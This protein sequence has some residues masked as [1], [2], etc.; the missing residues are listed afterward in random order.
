METNEKKMGVVLSYVIIVIN[1][2]VGFIYVPLLL[3]FLGDAQYG[4]YQLIGSLIAYMVLMD[5]GLSG[6]I[7]RYYSRYI[8]WKDEKGKE[9]VLAISSIIYVVLTLVAVVIGMLIYRNIDVIFG[10]KLSTSEIDL[11][12]QMFILLIINIAFTIPSNIFSAIINSNEKF[13]FMKCTVLFQSILK[14]IVIVM[15]LL[16]E[17]SAYLVVL[18]TTLFNLVVVL[19]NVYYCFGVLKT[20][21]KLHYWD[22]S[23]VNEMIKYAFYIFV[24]AL[25]DQ[26]FWR[27]NQIILGIFVGTSAVAIYAVSFQIVT[28]YMYLSTALSGVFLPSITKRVAEN[29][30]D[31]EMTDVFIRIGRL[32]YLLLGCVLSGFAL[33]GKQFI[34]LWVGSGYSETY[35]I[36]L[37]ILIPFTIDLIQNIG[38]AI[39]KA[40][41]LFA[42][43]GKVF[44]VI[45]IANV[46]AAVPLAIRYGG[47]GCALASGVAYFVGSTI[48]MNI[49]YHKKAKI[50]VIKFWR[51]IGNMTIPL[52]MIFAAGLFINRI[53]TGPAWVNF[54]FKVFS[55]M[56]LYLA[57]M[58]QMAM[59]TYEKS[60]ISGLFKHVF[61]KA[62]LNRA[63]R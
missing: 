25:I 34:R 12:K 58:W 39:L 51:E 38:L 10:E 27:T 14:P 32:Q 54:I 1:L 49:Y 5:F 30:S 56:I 8:A 40:K 6:T 13:I 47:I 3:H 50:D 16:R 44:I 48:F 61:V 28:N 2:V 60:L 17:P 55:Y 41:N 63:N 20:K 62:H 43:R 21:I 11:A 26:I 57:V 42:F 53:N 52:L 59:N 9:N 19:L 22:K 35:M 7:V 18:V 29:A 45:A 46:V 33:F 31:E 4:L 15:I 37:I 36:T 24:V 23:L